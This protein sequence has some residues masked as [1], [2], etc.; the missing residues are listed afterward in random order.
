MNS[1]VQMRIS[2][3]H[4]RRLTAIAGALNMNK[5]AAANELIDIAYRQIFRGVNPVARADHLRAE[6]Q[7]LAD[8]AQ[9]TPEETTP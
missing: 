7:L 5:T 3:E 1:M 4:C 9:T 8:L 2:S 6:D